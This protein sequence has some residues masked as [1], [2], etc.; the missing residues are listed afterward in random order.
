[1]KKFENKAYT[2]IMRKIGET[3][4]KFIE[5][6]KFSVN[7]IA[8]KIGTSNQN[9][10]KILKKDS[11]ETKY[12]EQIA[13]VLQINIIN[14][15]ITEEERV[16]IEEQEKKDRKE[17]L[18]EAIKTFGQFYGFLKFTELLDLEK[19]KPVIEEIVGEAIIVECFRM[20]DLWKYFGHFDN[21]EYYSKLA[22]C[23]DPDK[24]TADN[25]IQFIDDLKN[26][27]KK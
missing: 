4:K 3:V 5:D 1:M 2:L 23:I 26:A 22:E 15:F 11:I 20:Q 7:D 17:Y 14:F 8:E 12:L 19:A 25:L 21:K 9:L 10:Y 13:D 6:S 27:N 18:D 24:F 16:E